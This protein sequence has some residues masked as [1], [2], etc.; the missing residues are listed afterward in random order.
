MK[1]LVALVFV[2]G[3][4]VVGCGSSY[5][6]AFPQ[7]DELASVDK[8]LK[9]VWS[10]LGDPNALKSIDNVDRALSLNTQAQSETASWMIRVLDAVMEDQK[11]NGA[12]VNHQN[13]IKLSDVMANIEF[14]RI[15]ENYNRIAKAYLNLSLPDKAKSAYRTVIRSFE[16]EKFYSCNKDAGFG[17]EDAK[18]LEAKIEKEKAEQAQATKKIRKKAAK[19]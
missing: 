1:A 2:V 6:V 10:I 19:E 18:A 13:I 15:C 17:L 11:E 7:P 14:S 3:L 8:K 9:T 12:K 16:P 4:L 5:A